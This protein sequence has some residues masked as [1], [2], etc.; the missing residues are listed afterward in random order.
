MFRFKIVEAGHPILLNQTGLLNWAVLP[1]PDIIDVCIDPLHTVLECQTTHTCAWLTDC[2][3][4]TAWLWPCASEVWAG[5]PCL[6]LPTHRPLSTLSLPFGASLRA[7][8]VSS[9]MT[10]KAENKLNKIKFTLQLTLFFFCVCVHI[11]Y[12]S[13]N[14]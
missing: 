9:M 13:V 4:T 11:Y 12:I 14:I 8:A 2:H 1:C 10:G 3:R 7:A 6:S 5:T